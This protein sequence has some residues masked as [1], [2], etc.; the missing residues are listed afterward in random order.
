VYG[1]L[2]STMFLGL[3]TYSFTSKPYS[4]SDFVVASTYGM[5]PGVREFDHY[6]V[7]LASCSVR[8]VSLWE[9]GPS[10]ALLAGVTAWTLTRSARKCLRA[11]R[12]LGMHRWL[13][14]D[15]VRTPG[16][17]TAFRRT[18]SWELRPDFRILVPTH[19]N[20]ENV[21]RIAIYWRRTG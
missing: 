7:L 16:Q 19:R 18:A 8:G 17:W 1:Q 12:M 21:T 15:S 14:F 3:S 5:E 6:K 2:S 20:F 10:S 11:A 13:S 4:Y 9:S